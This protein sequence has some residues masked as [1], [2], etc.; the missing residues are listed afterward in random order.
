[1]EGFGLPFNR[2]FGAGLVIARQRFVFL[3]QRPLLADPPKA[4]PVILTTEEERDV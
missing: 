1:M 2:G 4:M 3:W